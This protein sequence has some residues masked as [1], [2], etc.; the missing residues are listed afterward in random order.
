MLAPARALLNDS[1]IR[2]DD[3]AEEVTYYHFMFDRHEIVFSNGVPT[4]SFHPA[5]GGIGALDTA[6]QDELFRLFPQLE[7]DTAAYGPLARATLRAF[8]VDVLLAA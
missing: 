3:G 4:E 8:E 1:S 2:V 5:S 7:H 6:K